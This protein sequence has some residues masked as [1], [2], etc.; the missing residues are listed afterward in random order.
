MLGMAVVRNAGWQSAGITSR[1][2]GHFQNWS[3]VRFQEPKRT[4]FPF[5]GRAGGKRLGYCSSKDRDWI[6]RG[7]SS[8][9]NSDSWAGRSALLGCGKGAAMEMTWLGLQPMGTSHRRCHLKVL[10]SP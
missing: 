1:T 10:L 6:S 5:G 7:T 3:F 4:S 9:I 8:A 2:A